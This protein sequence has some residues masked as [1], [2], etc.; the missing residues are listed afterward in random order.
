MKEKEK[1]KAKSKLSVE[2]NKKECNDKNCPFHGTLRIYSKKFKGIVTKKVQKQK[3]VT[4][5]FERRIFVAKYE[6]FARKT[7][8]IHAHLPDCMADL[9]NVGDMVEVHETRPISKT[10]HFVVVKK[11]R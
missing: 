11:I 9:I 8:K 4:I 2:E 1:S 6:R 3:K 7:T 10:I 5:E